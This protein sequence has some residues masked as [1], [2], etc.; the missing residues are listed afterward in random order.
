MLNCVVELGDGGKVSRESRICDWAEFCFSE[1]F[2]PA[3]MLPLSSE[4]RVNATGSTGSMKGSS[5]AMPKSYVRFNVNTI[6]AAMVGYGERIV[7]KYSQDPFGL[8][9]YVDS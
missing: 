8:Y 3:E 1:T 7:V 9:S 5:R 4:L 2:L 6:G